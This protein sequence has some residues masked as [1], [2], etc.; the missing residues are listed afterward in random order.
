MS[1]WDEKATKL[2]KC[3]MLVILDDANAWLLRFKINTRDCVFVFSLVHNNQTWHDTFSIKCKLAWKLNELKC[4]EQYQQNIIS[5]SIDYLV[6]KQTNKSLSHHCMIYWL[7][8]FTIEEINKHR[9]HALRL[10]CLI[11]IFFEILNFF[12]RIRW[13]LANQHTN[14][15]KMPGLQLITTQWMNSSQKLNCACR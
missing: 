5:P 8:H 3:I 1:I 15:I 2:K 14:S 4:A 13:N 6:P 10:I 12:V 11:E 9:R 7:D